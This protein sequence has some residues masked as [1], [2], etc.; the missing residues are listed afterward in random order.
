MVHDAG[1]GGQ[2]NVAEQTGRKQA[3]NPGLNLLRGHRR[4]DRGKGQVVRKVVRGMG[5]LLLRCGAAC[6]MHQTA[7]TSVHNWNSA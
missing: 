5:S 1:A 4:R 6:Q 7:K 2:H 3:G